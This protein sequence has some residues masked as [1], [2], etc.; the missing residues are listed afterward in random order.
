MLA[1]FFVAMSLSAQNVENDKAALMSEIE[2]N[3]T[4]LAAMRQRVIA[5]KQKN[6][7]SNTL[8]DPSFDFSNTWGNQP[9]SV[10]SQSYSIKQDLDWGTISGLRKKT[11][12]SSNKTADLNYLIQRQIL[13]AQVDKLIVDLTYG[14]ALCEELGIR[15]QRAAEIKELYE[16]KFAAGDADQL[17]LNKV[18]LNHTATIA[19]LRKAQADRDAVLNDLQRVNGNHPIIFTHTD[20][21]DI[22]LPPLA[23]LMKRAEA[24]APQ[25]AMVAN[26]IEEERQKLK[27]SKTE[28]LPE[29]TLGYAGSSARS[30]RTNAIT[31]GL[32]IPIWGN[33]QRKV[34]QQKAELTVAELEKEDV[35]TQIK[36]TLS[37]QYTNVTSLCQ[38]S[39]Q[40]K[41][42]L[43]A[44]EDIE[45][46]NKALKAGKLSLIDYLNELTFYY[47]AHTQAL[48]AEHNSQLALSE[49]WYMFR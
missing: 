30:N 40:F 2:K 49:L 27:L 6:S 12:N 36:S 10:T 47:S 32:S 46:L 14:N 19:E 23:E 44:N 7:L 13:L 16:K 22:P 41:K 28:G 31:V 35:E 9:N 25:I 18:R 29:L 4:T 11:I 34:K 20:Y 48:Q 24:N 38:I 45:I 26:T 33:S 15:E 42:E 43:H 37:K 1:L 3:N 17:E 8:P 21:A 39:D 5:D